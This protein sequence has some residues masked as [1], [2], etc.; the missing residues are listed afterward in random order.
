M[1]L[2]EAHM[3]TPEQ[4]QT[5]KNTYPTGALMVLETQCKHAAPCNKGEEGVKKGGKGG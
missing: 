1:N 2:L 3:H 4:K 5:H